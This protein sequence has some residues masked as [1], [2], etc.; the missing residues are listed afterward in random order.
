[1]MM[2]DMQAHSLHADAEYTAENFKAIFMLQA[3][4]L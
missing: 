1:M 2:L 4:K 3:L